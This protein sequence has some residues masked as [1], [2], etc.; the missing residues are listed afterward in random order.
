MPHSYTT[1]ARESI[2]HYLETRQL[3]EIPAYAPEELLDRQAGCFVTLYKDGKL[4]G[5]IGTIEPQQDTLAEEIIRNAVSSATEDPRF[6]S[7][8]KEELEHIAV[9]VDVLGVP[10]KIDSK[11]S[12]DPKRYGVIVSLRR[13]RGLLLPNLEGIDSADE[14]LDIALQKAGIYPDEPYQMERFLV[15]R[16]KEQDEG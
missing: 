9:S 4:R 13:R 5:C 8:K 6:P 2:T 15:V 16:H 11:E 10:E 1:L 14:Q 3:L 7:V 12:L